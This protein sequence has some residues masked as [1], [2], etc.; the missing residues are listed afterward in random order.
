MSTLRFLNRQ[1]TRAIHLPLLKKITSRAVA[2]AF[3]DPAENVSFVLG[4]SLV[5]P[6]EMARVNQTYLQ[7][8]GSTDVITFDYTGTDVAEGAPLAGEVY[9]SVADAVAYARQ[10]R[11][12][13][14]SELVRY[15][16]HGILHLRG[17]DDLQP[18]KRRVMK[19]EENRLVK[20][21]SKEF[22][23]KQLAK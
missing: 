14:P 8:E 11:T 1:K 16:V 3:D 18:A 17:F 13:W 7:H 19:R 15:I 2:L 5:E 22:D 12:T 20:A 21:L 4:V 10:F 6:D 23:L 9:I